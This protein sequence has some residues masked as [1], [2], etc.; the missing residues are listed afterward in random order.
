MVYQALYG[1]FATYIRPLE[2]FIS[3]VDQGKYPQVEQSYRFQYVGEVG[4]KDATKEA[5]HQPAVTEFCPAIEQPKQEGAEEPAVRASDSEIEQPK[6]EG[7]EEPVVGEA[8]RENRDPEQE[9]PDES[10]MADREEAACSEEI[11][12]WLDR[13]LDAKSFDEKYEIVCAMQREVT[14]RLIDDI[15]VVLDLAIPEGKLADRYAQLKHC[16]RTRQKYET[17]RLRG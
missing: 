8:D 7:A 4:E 17:G 16:I 15:A 11:N 9:S 1:D 12:P 3:P 13:I 10:A 5:P 14:D 6:Q 2:M